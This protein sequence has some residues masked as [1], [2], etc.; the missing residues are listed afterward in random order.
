MILA[1]VP[2]QISRSSKG[3]EMRASFGAHQPHTEKQLPSQTWYP[4][5]GMHM[6]Q[7]GQDWGENVKKLATYLGYKP[8]KR[9]YSSVPNNRWCWQEARWSRS[10]D[11]KHITL[12]EKDT[13][14]SAQSTKWPTIHGSAGL[15]HYVGISAGLIVALSQELSS[16]FQSAFMSFDNNFLSMQQHNSL[17][18]VGCSN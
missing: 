10:S 11:L 14:W 4:W 7:T 5:L 12:I 15:L 9:K 18:K 17:S 13:S 8:V 16:H 6:T 1:T 2:W 3:I